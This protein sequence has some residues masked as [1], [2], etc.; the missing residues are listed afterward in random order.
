MSEPATTQSPSDRSFRPSRRAWLQAAV[1]VAVGLWVFSPAFSGTLIWDDDAELT[2]NPVL[3]DPAGLLKVWAAPNLPDYFPLKSAV[4][5]VQWHL[6]G[7]RVL[8]YHLTNVALHLLAAMLLW[9]LFAG[10]G[11]KLAWLGALL[12]AIHPLTVESVAW[13]SELKN[14]LSLPLLLLAMLAYLDWDEG[15]A[16]PLGPPGRSRTG[17]ETLGRSATFPIKA[18]LWFLAAMLCKSSVVMF[19]VVILLY[20]WWRRGRVAWEDWRASLPFFGVALVLG[21]VTLWFQTTRAIASLELPRGGL[22]WHGACAAVATV[23]YFFKGLLP[24]DLMPIYPNGGEKRVWF[25]PLVC[26]CLLAGGLG[27]LWHRRAADGRG[28]LLGAGFFLI[29]LIPVL[30]FATMS[31]SRISRVADH[32]VYL[33]L[34]GLIGLAAAALGRIASGWAQGL[35]GVALVLWFAPESRRYA[36]IFRDGETF[37]SYA[38][39]HNPQ[40]W[41]ADNNLGTI[42]D[43]RG[44]LPAA[45]AHFERAL[46]S[47]PRYAEAENNLGNARLRQGREAEAIEHFHRALSFK[48][49]Y[50]EAY[51]DLGDALVQTGRL[52]E[53]IA[54]FGEALRLKPA[55]ANAY[56]NRGLALTGLGRKAEANADFVR[57]LELDPRLV[58]AHLNYG[59]A[60]VQAGQLAEGI[61]HYR[62]AL[63]LRPDFREA[64]NNLA[65]ALRLTGDLP[66]AVEQYL[67]ALRL[68]PNY[69][70][71]ENN[72]GVTLTDLGRLPE[73]IAHLEHAVAL[74]PGNPQPRQNL[75]NALAKEKR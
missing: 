51:D 61:A 68:D 72:L 50:A 46:R 74:A 73:A 27:W 10:L 30:G 6:W 42:L 17:N 48:P 66:A 13:I 70:D 41:L 65:N 39:A 54:A 63:R 55:Y 26:G 60:L 4:Q 18:L 15:R 62:E 2:L 58:E 28:A 37:W 12:F 22:L 52:P 47:N 23:F 44:E 14:V 53:A 35:I 33:P 64:H 8:F 69:G 56:S 19:P 1:L 21:A 11:L 36:G 16:R 59:R 71:A 75:A 20:A 31:Y 49:D 29:N 5:W 67:Q 9:R 32:L 43:R 38:I 25:Q 34:I 57:A 3:R 24:L 7:D 45:V 40:A